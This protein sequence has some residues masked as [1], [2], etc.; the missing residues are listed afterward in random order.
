MPVLTARLSAEE[1]RRLDELAAHRGTSRSAT[2]RHLLDDAAL[3]RPGRMSL[4]EALDLLDAKARDGD[5]R[6]IVAVIDRFT[7]ERARSPDPRAD[8]GL[9]VVQ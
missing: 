8:F 4:D 6:A 5:F 7:A 2:V 1:L 9:R 3:E